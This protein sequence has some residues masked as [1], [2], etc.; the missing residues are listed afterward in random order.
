MLIQEPAKGGE[1][2]AGGQ[3]KLKPILH[4][5]LMS[6]VQ[7]TGE[8]VVVLDREQKIT[9]SNQA[10]RT[11]F[12]EAGVGVPFNLFLSR[13]SADAFKKALQAG[14]PQSIDIELH[15]P[16][17]SGMKVVTYRF[18]D[19]GIGFLFGVGNDRS[20]E[21]EVVTQMAVLIEELE[22]EIVERVRLAQRLEELAITDALTGVNNRRHFDK[23]FHQE[24]N[25]WQR[26]G[27]QFGLL[28]VDIDHF[29]NVNDTLGHQAGDEVLKQVGAV[30]RQEVRTEDTV[31]RYGGEE[32]AILAIGVDSK[33]AAELAERLLH[34]IHQTAMPVPGNRV[35]VSI[36]L[37]TPEKAKPAN[38]EH[39]LRMADIALYRAK[40]NGRDRVEVY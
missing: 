2:A 24:W 6:W 29:K 12:P 36:G 20:R 8:Y 37:A 26:Y 32:F 1:L 4:N 27:S 25:R 30:L 17:P 19:I 21:M 11:V 23:V 13:S 33:G 40:E 16:I 31:A 10:F 18:V 3:E 34:K 7:D 35:T 39:L 14:S 28:I 38:P 22:H 9:W 5:L 15:H